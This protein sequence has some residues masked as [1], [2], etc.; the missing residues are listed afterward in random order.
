MHISM[1]IQ[2]VSSRT[3]DDANKTTSIEKIVKSQQTVF[4]FVSP[5]SNV[6]SLPNGYIDISDEEEQTREVEKLV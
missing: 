1:T 6:E 5:K 3:S 2:S 4:N